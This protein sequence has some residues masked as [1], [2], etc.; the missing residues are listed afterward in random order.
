M[1][2]CKCRKISRNYWPTGTTVKSQ[3]WK[4]YQFHVNSN[5]LVPQFERECHRRLWF[6]V[7]VL[8]FKNKKM[9][10]VMGF[11]PL[12]VPRIF[13]HNLFFFLFLFFFQADLWIERRSAHTIHFQGS[14]IWGQYRIFQN[15]SE[16]HHHDHLRKSTILSTPHSTTMYFCNSI[17]LLFKW[18]NALTLKRHC[19]R[20][21][22]W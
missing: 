6:L 12:I 20:N 14:G 21:K 2:V 3:I 5:Y 18:N 10:C 7:F 19:L 13:F 16:N 1:F 22:N 15:H 8:L 11:A 17:L 4:I 9:E